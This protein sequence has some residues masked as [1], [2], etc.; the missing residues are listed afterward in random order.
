MIVFLV[1]MVIGLG[2]TAP[3]VANPGGPPVE[4]TADFTSVEGGKTTAGQYLFGNPGVRMEGSEGGTS[5]ITMFV[6]STNKIISLIP[7][8]RMS[9]EIPF[10]P[11]NLAFLSAGSDTPTACGVPGEA[12]LLGRET[13]HGRAVEKWR[14]VPKDGTAMTEPM[15]VW[16]DTRLQ[17]HIRIERDNGGRFELTNIQERRVDPGLFEIPAGY[18]SPFGGMGGMFGG[19]GGGTPQP[20][21]G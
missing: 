2:I 8:H 11:E 1:A 17:S 21:P 14:C 4:F 10:D 20:P 16:Y 7:E 3:L 15:T 12:T 13:L 18:S 9:I 5:F 6:R 19:G